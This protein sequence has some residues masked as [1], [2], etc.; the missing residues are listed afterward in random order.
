MRIA[1]AASLLKA[2]TSESTGGTEAFAHILTE[3][4]VKKG[5]DVTLFAT[6]DS[7]T[8]AKLESVASSTQT[9]GF[10]WRKA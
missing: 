3:G 7:K 2:I 9:T 4:L 8:S 5:Q 6:S 1:V 10:W